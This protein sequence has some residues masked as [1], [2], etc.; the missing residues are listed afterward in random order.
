MA[1]TRRSFLQS[2][3]GTAMGLALPACI[4]QQNASLSGTGVRIQLIRNATGLVRYGGKTLLIDPFLSDGGVLPP[5]NN[6][7]NPRP[8]PLVP[9]PIP[10]AQIVADVDATLVTHTHVDHWDA[11]AQDL[12]PKG[13]PLFGQP[14]NSTRLKDAGFTDVRPVDATITWSDITIARTGGQHGRGDVGQRMGT[15]SGYVL[16]RTGLP[17][18]YFAGFARR[19]RPFGGEINRPDSSRRRGHPDRVVHRPFIGC[20]SPR[21]D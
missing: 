5:F 9:L 10:A 13:G 7:P 3:A 2:T 14:A 20:R 15:V 21:R 1:I 11:V 12:L 16:T 19:A 6:T 4:T 8:N 17:T 18:V